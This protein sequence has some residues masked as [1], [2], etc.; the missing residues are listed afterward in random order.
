MREARHANIEDRSHRLQSLAGLRF[1]RLA[2]ECLA[3]S[4][5]L[6]LAAAAHFGE[7][8]ADE[9]RMKDGKVTFL[10]NHAGG[11]LGG[12]SSGQDIVARLAV[13]PTSSILTPVRSVDRHGNDIEIRTTGRH[14]PCVGI[15]ATPVAEAI[16]VP[17]SHCVVP[18]R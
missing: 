3:L 6:R 17:A 8:N 15:R 2:S 16:N 13:K 4:V 5:D 14:D 11:I 18:G 7:D 9:M 12:I 1:S 10:A